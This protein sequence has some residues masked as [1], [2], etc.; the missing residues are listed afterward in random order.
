[1][2]GVPEVQDARAFTGNLH[3]LGGRQ[4]M[5][6]ATVWANWATQLKSGIIQFK[7]GDR[8]RLVVST[9]DIMTELWVKNNNGLLERPTQAGL[10]DKIGIDISSMPFGPQFRKC[11]QAGLVCSTDSSSHASN[12]QVANSFT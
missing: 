3:S 12:S 1:M 11:R 8:R 7:M 2:P 4:K 9:W 6:D 10:S 5:N